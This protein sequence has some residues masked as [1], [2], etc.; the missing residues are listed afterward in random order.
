MNLLDNAKA[1]RWEA[2][3]IFCK[4]VQA[5]SGLLLELGDILGSFFNHTI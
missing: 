4:V 5:F 3:V 1:H 2:Q